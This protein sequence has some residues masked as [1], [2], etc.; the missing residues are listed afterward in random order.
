MTLMDLD[1]R[2]LMLGGAASAAT[3]PC[4]RHVDVR[5]N[6]MQLEERASLVG[7]LGKTNYTVLNNG[8]DEKHGEPGGAVEGMGG[9]R[10]IPWPERSDSSKMGEK[11][12]AG[13]A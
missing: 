3:V 6:P 7:V 5:A 13:K 11:R 12:N 1:H 8:E 10:E 9:N 4:G 2:E